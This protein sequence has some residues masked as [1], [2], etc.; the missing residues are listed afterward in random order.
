MSRPK[1]PGFANSEIPTAKT[2]RQVPIQAT[3]V[4]DVLDL[5]GD[6]VETLALR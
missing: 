1:A 5:G 2:K 4:V 3:D 6:A